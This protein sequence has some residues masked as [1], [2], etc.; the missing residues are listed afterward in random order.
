MIKCKYGHFYD[1][2]VNA[3]C[4]F[5]VS[6]ANGAGG[7]PDDGCVGEMECIFGDS[8]GKRY[9]LYSGINRVGRGYQMDVCVD[10]DLQIMRD[11]HCS[12]LYDKS[13]DEFTIIPSAGSVTYV[14]NV[15]LK[16]PAIISE[17]DV[18]RIGRSDLKLIKCG[19]RN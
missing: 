10:G 7:I 6:N 18:L 2:K 13:K 16:H 9:R 15:I 4:P 14:N 12:I 17:K 5:C 11:N 3:V 1:E 19:R 8:K